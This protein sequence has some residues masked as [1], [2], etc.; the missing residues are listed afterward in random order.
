MAIQP[1]SIDGIEFDALIGTEESYESD[2]PQYPVEAGYEVG[3]T[4]IN[5]TLELQMIVYVSNTPVS[6][7]EQFG[8]EGQAGTRVED[9][10]SRLKKMRNNRQ[11]VTIVTN[12]N[13]YKNMALQSM[14]IT[15]TTEQ[16]YAREI[17]CTF[18]EVIITSS[19]TTSI[20]SSYG[21][22]GSSG[23]NGGSASTSSSSSSDAPKSI[24]N[25]GLK[26]SGAKGYQ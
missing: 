8:E 10:I 23:T 19:K 6:H 16:G 21:K 3:D 11:L 20:P 9:V 5:K 26:G 22:S 2:V 13:T 14:T 18:K 4:I 12:D 1:C 15:K 24:L 7:Y 25:E 17:P